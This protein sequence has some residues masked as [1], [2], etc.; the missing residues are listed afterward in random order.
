LFPER[1]ILL[2]SSERVRSVLLPSWL[3]AIAVIACVGVFGG[4]SYLAI[5]YFAMH[6]QL[7]RA[8][9]S[10]RTVQVAAKK[11]TNTEADAVAALN[12]ELAS[13]NEQYGA[14]KQ[15]YDAM[16]A[17]Q[18]AD[19][20]ATNQAQQALQQKLDQA[21]QQLSANSGNVAQLKKSVDDLRASLKRSEQERGVETTH[22][23]Q[24]EIE[25]QTLAARANLLKAI[26][27]SKDEQLAR[28]RSL[29]PKSSE[30]LGQ[31]PA[32]TTVVPPPAD[33]SLD[34]DPHKHSA[35]DSKVMRGSGVPA[36]NVA[37]LQGGAAS[38]HSPS[39]LEQILASTGV[40]IDKMLRHVNS[41]SEPDVGGPFIALDSMR[42]TAAERRRV[43]ALL[44][45]AKLLPLR[46]PLAIRYEIGS[47]FGPRLDPFNHRAAFHTGID[48]DA[49]YRTPV[50]STAPGIVIFTGWQEGYGRTIEINHGHGIVTLYAHLHRILVARGEH[51][52]AHVEIGQLGSTGRS[53]G[54]HLHYEIRLDG[55]PVNPEKFLEAGK[56]V[57]QA[58]AH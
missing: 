17:G 30:Q 32:G 44:K 58:S 57:V 18:S 43:A 14:L 13:T 29:L 5:S 37:Q 4:V 12:Q 31:V 52:A 41:S 54:P 6:R 2:R 11:T 49:P 28:L 47:P 55:R 20:A 39:R 7:E 46:S 24:L 33:T 35:L 19:A 26:V 3:Q 42:T 56:N 21:E 25:M 8:S 27:D 15:R 51:V 34:A 40:D 50:Y 10:S 16:V 1:Q 36:S 22:A 38:H 9:A 48:L 53:T 45:I 23:H